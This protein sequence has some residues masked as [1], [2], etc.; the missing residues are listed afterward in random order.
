MATAT[1]NTRSTRR[2]PAAATRNRS[3]LRGAALLRAFRPGSELL[4]N[5][6]LA[7][8]TGLPKSTVSRLTQTLMETG[9][10]QWESSQLAYRLAPAVLSLGHAMRMGSRVLSVA[11]PGMRALAE[12]LRIN[13]GLASPDD[14]EMVYLESIRYS[15][16]ISLR[17]V[18]SGQRIPMATTSLGRAYLASL[19]IGDFNDWIHAFRTHE[20]LKDDTLIHQIQEARVN[21]SQN[22]F[23]AASWQTS[24]VALAT[25]LPLAGASYALNVSLMTDESI[26]QVSDRLSGPL[27]TLAA[28]IQH[29][30][31]K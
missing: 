9:F 15:R 23:C 28:N 10:L 21:V 1:E 17:N 7:E 19:A 6:E 2:K 22:G 24:V 13:V 25:P 31:S 4:G 26:Q 27:K 5:S 16:R 11:A 18:V 8:R 12:K 30:L 14:D 29:Q 20:N 3:L